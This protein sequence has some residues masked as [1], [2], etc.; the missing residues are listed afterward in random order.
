[1][2]D[3]TLAVVGATGAVGTEFLRIIQTRHPELHKIKLL[4]SQR[5]AGKRLTVNGREL[6]VEETTE[7]SFRGVGQ[8]ITAR[9][10]L[11]ARDGPRRIEGHEVPASRRPGSLP[12]QGC[13]PP[14]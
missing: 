3:L 7:D 4:A 14:P 1:M 11:R 10:R 13:H 2:Q 9:G 8:N 12:G 6:V 5:S